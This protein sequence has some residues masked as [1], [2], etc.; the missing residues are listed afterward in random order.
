MNG[1]NRNCGQSMRMNAVKF[2]LPM[3]R[4]SDMSGKKGP[5]PVTPC[6]QALIWPGHRPDPRDA[7]SYRLWFRVPG[8]L[9]L[10][11]L[12]AAP[13]D[14]T[15]LAISNVAFG[16]QSPG[17]HT[18]DTQRSA[19]T[20]AG[21]TAAARTA[22]G[23]T[24]GGHTAAGRTAVDHQRNS[25][26]P[27]EQL[28][29]ADTTS[30]RTSKP[31]A[32]ATDSEQI[33]EQRLLHS[34]RY[35]A[36]DELEGR[37]VGTDG[38]DLAAEYI[39][40]QFHKTALKTDLFRGTPYHTFAISS[41]RRMGTVRAL[42]IHGPVTGAARLKTAL[43][44]VDTR[45]ERAGI[46]TDSTG[47]L[48]LKS[49]TDFTALTLSESQEFDL[50]LAFVGYGITDTNIAYDD[51]A[52]LNV[53]GKAVVI[54]RNEP[55]RRDPS[56]P[57]NGAEDSEHAFI[58]RKLKNA[59]EHGAAAVILCTD[60]Q[61]FEPSADTA[62]ETQ[63]TPTLATEQLLE[64]TVKEA[65]GGKRIPVVHCR[66]QIVA[67]LIKAA[68]QVDLRDLER[69][70]N[71]RLKPKSFELT[72][73]QLRGRVAAS[74]SGQVLKNVIGQLT[75]QGTLA[76]ETIVVG[77]H[78]DHLGMG[79]WGSLS[80]GLQDEVH[81][82]A[83]DNASG[84]AVML[85]IARQLQQRLKG[86]HRQIL[87]I[88]F[89]AE[90]QGLVGSERYVRDPLV[91]L[92][93]T[94]AMINLDMVG[95]LRNDELTAYGT[96][97]AV[98]FSTIVDRLATAHR[99]K[100]TQRPDGYGPSDHASF[101]GRGVP[102]LHFF[103][104]FH[105]EYHRPSD[106]FQRLNIAGMRRIAMLVTDLVQVLAEAEHPPRHRKTGTLAALSPTPLDV[107]TT[108]LLPKSKR[109]LLGVTGDP[110]Y[111]QPGYFVGKLVK[112]GPA[113]SAG[114]R[115]GDVIVR[116]ADQPIEAPDD[117]AAVV[118]Q[119]QSGEEVTVLIRRGRLE[120]ELNVTIGVMQY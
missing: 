20:T 100:I 45:E 42:E 58:A 26:S 73:W 3:R 12:I 97:T 84:T 21:H 38:L 50:P 65:F 49:G 8:L 32:T 40:E 104:G 61:E 88:G 118:N 67:E 37:G 16:Y 46:P 86:N 98:E 79:G 110:R 13:I 117:L 60:S 94:V 33:S 14:L 74:G 62:T 105:P 9:V 99:L 81:N 53:R 52:G 6:R 113:E 55:Q 7:Q 64:F 57:F 89:S 111:Q 36:S 95:R 25:T 29:F 69:A 90:E 91:P 48:P 30:E 80:F 18:V 63:T 41:R 114:C 75:G 28:A 27:S 66:R 10:G 34:V 39:A 82:G 93:Q 31:V 78:Y 71:T 112:N 17:T 22:G 77:A 96:G 35:L 107:R 120:L 101:Y 70:I 92:E 47:G 4:R 83:D 76:E 56:S 102:V 85:E 108:P 103:T 87:F 1:V 19:R 44:A 68:K 115:V 109:V 59:V 24:A 23:H 2:Q 72:G 116:V 11:L 106:D 43:A 51:Y 119:F 5:V 54:L 15:P